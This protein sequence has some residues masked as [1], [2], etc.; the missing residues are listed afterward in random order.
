MKNNSLSTNLKVCS[1]CIY[2]ERVPYITFDEEGICKYCHQL[3][4]LKHEYGT[5]SKKGEETFTKIIEE[6]KKAG[7]GKKYDCIIGVSG[8]TDSSYMLYLTKVWGLRPLAVHYDNTWNSAIAT[9]NIRKVLTALDIDLYTHVTDNKEADDIFKSFFYADVAE[10][11]AS[12]DLALAEVMYR[13]AW[14]YKVKYVLEGHSFMEEGI[15]PVGRNYFDGKYI[16]SIHNK[17]GK[18]PM[19]SYPLMTF[20]RFLFST[21]FAKIQKIR[22]FWY[23]DYNKDDAKKF[24]EKEY[25]W[26]YYGGH[27]LE[28]RMTAYFHSI[29]LPQKFNGDMRNNTLAALVRNGKMS[30]EEGW[31]EYNTPP[32]VEKDLVEYFKKRLDLSDDEYDRVMKRKPKSWTEYPTYKK[33]FELL[34]PLFKILAKANLVPMSFYLKYC[35]PMPKDGEK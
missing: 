20:S 29:Y 22:P 6:I 7:K 21:M 2:D 15:T 9:E 5:A 34:R 33:R 19:K 30:R 3:E 8:G 28:N 1:K 35:F 18:L 27:H 24:L 32:H 12:T 16:K 10:I 26:K 17:F 31:E 25:D 14:K 13:V 23:I 4:K 11:E